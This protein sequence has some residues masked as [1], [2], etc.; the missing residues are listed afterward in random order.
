MRVKVQVAFF[1]FK[2]VLFSMQR[3]VICGFLKLVI[4]S[5][6]CFSLTADFL[7]ECDFL[8]D[9]VLYTYF[10]IFTL[11]LI[12]KQNVGFDRHGYCPLFANP[13]KYI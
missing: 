2:F 4:F 3:K 1:L 7:K 8:E 10:T 11:V 5:I 12:T 13:Y 6:N 9:D